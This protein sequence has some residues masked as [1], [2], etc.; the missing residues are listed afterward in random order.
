MYDFVF[1]WGLEADS[2]HFSF[3]VGTDY[4]DM[5][6]VKAGLLCML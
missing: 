1:W 5:H 2:A 4:W 3:F 6:A